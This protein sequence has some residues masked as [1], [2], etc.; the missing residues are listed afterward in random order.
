MDF[1]KI[2][3]ASFEVHIQSSLPNTFVTFYPFD[4]S[5]GIILS[6]SV[7][8]LVQMAPTLPPMV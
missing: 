3:Q 1:H 6:L 8:Y 2:P 7:Q 5:F 4:F